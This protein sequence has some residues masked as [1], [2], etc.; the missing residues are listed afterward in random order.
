MVTADKTTVQYPN[1]DIHT[2]T[3]KVQNI[4]NITKIPHSFIFIAI[5][6]FLPPSRQPH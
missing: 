1:Q 6:P 2:D 5:P 3:V 4:S